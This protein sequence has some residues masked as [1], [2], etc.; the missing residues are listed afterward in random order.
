[1]AFKDDLLQHVLPATAGAGVMY[2]FGEHLL[3]SVLTG[4]IIYLITNGLTFAIKNVFK[5][6]FNKDK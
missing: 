4:L 1:M 5:K 6:F 2:S 3:L